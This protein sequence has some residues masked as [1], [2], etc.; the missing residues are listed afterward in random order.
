MAILLCL[1]GL[2][3]AIEVD[4]QRAREYNVDP[5]E[6]QK[7]APN[8]LSFHRIPQTD[9]HVPYV[10]KYIEAKPGKP[11]CFVL[12]A[13]NFNVKFDDMVGAK[14]AK[15]STQVSMDGFKTRTR[16]M[17]IGR[18][19]KR[20]C[21]KTGNDASGW[22]KHT[23]RFGRLNVVE[24]NPGTSQL[25]PQQA[26]QCGSLKVIL[27]L[28][29][30]TGRFALSK[31]SSGPMP[32]HSIGEKELKGRAV[33]SKVE[34]DSEPTDRPR[35]VEQHQFVDP[36]YRPIAVFEFRYRT[37]EGLHQELIVPHPVVD[38]KGEDKKQQVIDV[39]DEYEKEGKF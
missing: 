28:K 14:E 36:Q 34:F 15:I 21:C 3:V 11:F 38:V 17:L 13:T 4:G 10:L 2:E 35:S 8:E 22:K 24:G 30:D 27:F 29:V 9:R 18:V 5:E 37:M 33:D 19:V 23:F 20:D 39:E 7:C 16:R 26:Q 31:G 12:D 1:P 6:V 25:R 32:I